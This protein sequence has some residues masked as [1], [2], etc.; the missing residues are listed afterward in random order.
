MSYLVVTHLRTFF[1]PQKITQG[2]LEPLNRYIEAVIEDL[3]LD[4]IIREHTTRSEQPRTKHQKKVRMDVCPALRAK[5]VAVE[6]KYVNADGL[7]LK[8]AGIQRFLREF[9][10]KY[11]SISLNFSKEDIRLVNSV[12]LFKVEATLQFLKKIAR[13]R[14]VRTINRTILGI[15]GRELSLP[16]LKQQLPLACRTPPVREDDTEED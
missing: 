3:L 7:K 14:C 11:N 16:S 4:T 12:V 9:P 15:A 10:V 13:Y 5:L 2:I 8:V 1:K 6:E